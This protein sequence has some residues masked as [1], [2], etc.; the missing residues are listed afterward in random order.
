M[1]VHMDERRTNNN[2]EIEIDLK[3]L[4]KILLRKAW[5][6]GLTA[7]VCAVAVFLGTFCFVEPEYQ[8]STMFYVNNSNRIPGDSAS[9]ITASDINASRGLVKSYIAI[10]NTRESINEIIEVAGVNRTYAEVAGMISADAVDST[11]IIEVV[12]TSTN[13]QEAKLIADAVAV[14]LPQRISGIIDGSS[15]KV[16]AVAVLPQ[17]PSS[18]SY[19][20]NT[21]IGF[22]G[23]MVLMA[24]VVI[25]WALMDVRVH[26][27]EDIAQ[28]CTYPILAAVPD[29]AAESGEHKIY[30]F[31]KQK[32][33]GG[34]NAVKNAASVQVV[35]RDISFPAQEAYKLLRTK[36]Q[37]SFAD[38]SNCR[39]IGICSALPGEGKSLSSVNLAYSV[40]QLGKRV[41]LIDCDMRCSSISR[42]LPVS[43]N[44][45]LSDFLSGQSS[46]SNLIQAC[47]LKDDERAFHVISSGRTPPNPVELLS[48]QRMEKMLEYLRS[49]YD[50]IILDLPPV[51]EVSDALAVAKQIDGVVL[52]VRQN[53]CD[54]TALTEAVRQF[55]FLDARIL[56]VVFNCTVE[57]SNV[58]ANGNPKN[59]YYQKASRNQARSAMRSGR[60]IGK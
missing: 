24:A 16:V 56:G 25:L 52:V 4:G 55:E 44:H 40:S 29:M 50:Y 28:L 23:G 37:F 35:G 59:G 21:L 45:G 34:K 38:E 39:V 20:K 41:L 32:R 9:N 36:L 57:E 2:E 48:S 13:R 53:F 47:G 5:L 46:A 14:V 22:L 33:S 49:K 19:S 18:P 12:V 15:A 26:T 31:A 1:E 51:G 58:Y 17:G 43:Q 6:I 54:R 8:A 10:L 27:E 3:R 42:K 30:G 11:E 7:V 60:T